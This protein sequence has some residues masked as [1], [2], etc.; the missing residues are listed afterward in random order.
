MPTNTLPEWATET[1]TAS[2]GSPRIAI[3]ATAAY[4]ALLD[5][6]RALY[7]ED[8]NIPSEWRKADG[9]LKAEY[10]EMLDDLRSDEPSAY[11][12]EVCYQAMKLDVRVAMRRRDLQLHIRDPERVYRQKARKRGRGP[13]RAAGGLQGGKEA[14]EHY[15]RLRGFLPV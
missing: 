10:A 1:G 6:Y 13:E 3:D 14:R 7:A 11:W 8:R 12:L 2:S 9:D 15:R 4:P 5:E